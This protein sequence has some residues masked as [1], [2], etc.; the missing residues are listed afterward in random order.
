REELLNLPCGSTIASASFLKC[1]TNTGQ[2]RTRKEV[3]MPK[4]C[5]ARPP[6]DAAEERRVRRLA[7]SRHAPRDCLLRAGMGALTWDAVRS[8]DIAAELE[9]HPHTV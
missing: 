6:A 7:R 3:A 8:A 2:C 1:G 4:L 5:R 9:C